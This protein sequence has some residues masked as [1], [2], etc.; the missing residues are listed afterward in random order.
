MTASRVLGPYMPSTLSFRYPQ[1]ISL[2]WM[3]RTSSPR[4]PIL[5]NAST[6]VAGWQQK[7]AAVNSVSTSAEKIWN[8]RLYRLGDAEGAVWF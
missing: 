8:S 7:T 6:V 5:D 3:V 2:V 1:R 4:E